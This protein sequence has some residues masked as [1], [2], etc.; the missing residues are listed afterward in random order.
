MALIQIRRKDNPTKVVTVD[1]VHFDA[2]L[3]KYGF[4]EVM[5][6][7]EPEPPKLTFKEKVLK[8]I[9]EF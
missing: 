6:Y 4:W 7:K 5:P 3:K 9:M 1:N 2:V 8:F